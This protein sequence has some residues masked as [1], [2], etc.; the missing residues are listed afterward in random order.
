[1]R[2]F[3]CWLFRHEGYDLG[4]NHFGKGRM[5]HTCQKTYWTR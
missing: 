5:C 4:Y 3:L 1:M 2:R